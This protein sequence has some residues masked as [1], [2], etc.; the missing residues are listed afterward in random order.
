MKRILCLVGLSL[1]I[2]LLVAA[3]GSAAIPRPE[4][5]ARA[6]AQTEIALGNITAT[7]TP[8]PTEVPPTATNTDVPTEI[9]P[10]ATDVAPTE[11]PA[12]DIPPSE[13]PTEEAV[14]GNV[15]PTEV[16]SGQTPSEAEIEAAVALADPELGLQRIN[17]SVPPCTSCHFLDSEDTLIGPGLL[18]LS[19]RAGTRVPGEGPYTYTYNAIRYSQVHIVEGFPAGLMPSYDG[20][21]NDEAVYNII[22]YLWTLHD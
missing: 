7:Y 17:G 2:V 15:T 13:V 16:P 5:D 21:L 22:A 20:V 12:T 8:S 10:T 1:A 3:C 19:E 6:E 18:N 11:V 9:P 14:S 4:A